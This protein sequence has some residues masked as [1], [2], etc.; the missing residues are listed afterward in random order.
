METWPDLRSRAMVAALFSA[1]SRPASRRARFGSMLAKRAGFDERFDR[2]FAGQ[3]ALVDAGAEVVQAGERAAVGAG[4]QNGLDG[5]LADV[6]DG[7]QAEADCRA[8]AQ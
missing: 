5:G 4:G 1:P 6:L 2:A 7:E 8:F 3:A